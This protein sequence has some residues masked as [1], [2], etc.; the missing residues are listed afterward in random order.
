[1][2][3]AR[4]LTPHAY[5]LVALAN[6]FVVLLQI[7]TVGG[8]SQA[9]VQRRTVDRADLDTI[10][11]IGMG[12]SCSLAVVL[13]L[14]AWPLASAFGEPDLR[15]VLQALSVTF[16]TVGIGT[17]HQ[18]VLQRRLAFKPIAVIT[19]AANVI[20]TIVGV[21]FAVV[22]FGVW[23][24]V[25]QT[26]LGSFVTSVGLVALSGY[27]PGFAVSSDRFGALFASSRHFLGI[28]LLGFLNQRTDDFLVGGVLGSVVLGIY[29]VAYRVLTVM[30]DV[31]STTARS[32]AFPVFS[33]V[34]DERARLSRAYSSV[35]RMA[36]AVAFPAFMWVLAAAPETVR[37]VFGAKWDAA[38]PVMR[39][40]C[41]FGPLQL[42]A[43]LNG[44]L[45]QSV[46]RARLVFRLMVAGTA[47]QVVAFVIAV[48][49]G[50][51]WVAASYVIRAYLTVWPGLIV[52]ARAVDATVRE[53]MAGVVAPLVSSLVMVGAVLA[54]HTAL[55]ALS[56][57][58]RLLVLLVVGAATYLAALAITGRGT[59][60]EAI[61]LARVAL[62]RGGAAASA[63]LAG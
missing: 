37:V 33:R 30:I 46:G 60:K 7:I 5:G 51:S 41:L 36:S 54:A 13:S 1:V 61:A 27:R 55:H 8:M 56:A 53:Q 10:F 15:P 20:A 44:A 32:V 59:L 43:Q 21:A 3:L 48:P 14:A 19:I 40:L 28:S 24:L 50:I 38:V 45:L 23:S 26:V 29:S 35:L 57:G 11:W 6:V 12:L 18:A 9:L 31:V 47:L 52:A 42:V 62:K 2:V 16:I 4:L 17:T 22:G 39:I 25:V 34:Q 49:Y 63:D 58:P